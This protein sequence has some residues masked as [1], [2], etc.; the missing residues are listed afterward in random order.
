MASFFL[1]A[2]ALLL[3]SGCDESS[4]DEGIPVLALSAEK[5]TFIVDEDGSNPTAQAVDITNTG[6]GTLG[7]T[8]ATDASWL[9]V[10]PSSGDTGTETDT[11]S[12]DVD[13][14]GLS[15]GRHAAAVTI[16]ASD[17][18]VE[19]QKVHVTLFVIPGS[20]I[21]PV[22]VSFASHNEDDERYDMY[23]TQDGYEGMREAILKMMDVVQTHDI[24]F[25][26]QPDWRF[27]QAIKRWETDALVATTNNKN[28]LRHLKEDLGVSIDPHSHE[29]ATASDSA[30]TNNPD[31]AD[32]CNYADVAY[33]IEELGVNPAPIVGGFIVNPP[34]NA[35][36]EKFRSPLRGLVSPDYHW[37]AESL[38]GGGSPQHIDDPQFSGLWL[39]MDHF[40]F[41]TDDPSQNLP[42]IG[43]GGAAPIQ[44]LINR[45]ETGQAPTGRI[46]TWTHM[47]FE[48]NFY[49]NG[50][51]AL[52]AFERTLTQ[53]A[54]YANQG[55]VIYATLPEILEIWRSVYN[56]EPNIYDRSPP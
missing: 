29:C 6:S 43:N 35:I 22:F 53:L 17:A 44:D 34:S 28:I 11:I 8:L 54:P 42:N 20:G 51:S 41:A 38:W 9:S 26:F 4:H 55:K 7:W 32:G 27:L 16:S 18:T 31:F 33:L 23:D 25:D 2:T 12:V 46:Y 47:E 30:K 40:N 48:L 21:T 14:A 3:S 24:P 19:T 45:I 5:L 1:L 13:F 15:A 37:Q 36:W 39:P 56:S 49:V 10:T 52:T 50:D